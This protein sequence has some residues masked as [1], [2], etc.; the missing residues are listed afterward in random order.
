[1]N[2]LSGAF[3]ATEHHEPAAKKAETS[4]S[5]RRESATYVP[6]PIE[7]YVINNAVKLGYD[8]KDGTTSSGC[9][10]WLDEG[11][12]NADIHKKLLQWRDELHVY[13]K[14]VD[15]FQPINDIRETL[16]CETLELHN[17][18]LS[19]IFP[20]G[21]LSRTISHG[22]VEP[23]LPPMRH[24]S[25]CSDPSFGL[26][27]KYL[28]HDFAAMCRTL[29]PRSRTVFVNMGASMKFHGAAKSPDTELVELFGKFGFPFDHIYAYELNQEDPSNVYNNLLPSSLMGAYH[30]INVGVDPTPNG[31][32]NPFELLKANFN[33]DDLIIVKLDIDTPDIEMKFVELLLQDEALHTL[34]DQLYFEHHVF[35]KELSRKWRESMK[36]SVKY[37]LDIFHELRRVGIPA[38]FWV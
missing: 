4:S 3:S 10:I 16:K 23:L 18:G 27:T 21:Q 24:P 6:A 30:W 12:T 31:K 33:E 8:T 29:S 26:D 25:F 7:A 9:T 11:V 37:S 2:D 32:M 22:C 5:L 38:H 35:L 19:G 14:L 36:G 28:V 34:I 20:S 13:N 17:D 15:Q 1:M